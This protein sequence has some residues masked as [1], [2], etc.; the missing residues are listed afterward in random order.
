MIPKVMGTAANALVC[1]SGALSNHEC[2]Q[3]NTASYASHDQGIRIAAMSRKVELPNRKS[4]GRRQAW[5]R[6]I[7][8]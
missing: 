2:R 3:G 8:A 1:P 5:I 6:P 7:F 4:A